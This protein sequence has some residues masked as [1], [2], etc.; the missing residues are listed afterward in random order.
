MSVKNVSSNA[1]KFRELIVNAS[2][3]FRA[4]RKRRPATRAWTI[5]TSRCFQ[6]GCA[7]GMLKESADDARDLNRYGTSRATSGQRTCD[8]DHASWDEF[9]CALSPVRQHDGSL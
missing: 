1:A 7:Q 6:R 3:V 4:A 8:A 9:H 5:G 2:I